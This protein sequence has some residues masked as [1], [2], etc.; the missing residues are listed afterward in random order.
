MGERGCLALQALR[1]AVEDEDDAV[2]NKAAEALSSL[3]TPGL[4]ILVR[5]VRMSP[6]PVKRRAVWGLKLPIGEVGRMDPAVVQNAVRVLIEALA[7]KDVQIRRNAAEAL[8]GYEQHAQPAIPLLIRALSDTH[9]RVRV[10][11]AQTLAFLPPQIGGIIAPAIHLLADASHEVFLEIVSRLAFIGRRASP[12]APAIVRRLAN[13]KRRDRADINHA[14]SMFGPDAVPALAELLKSSNVRKRWLAVEALGEF[15]PYCP[16]AI[17][18]LMAAFQDADIRVRQRATVALRLYGPEAELA[19]PSLVDLLQSPNAKLRGAAARALVQL[20]P[21]ARSARPILIQAAKDD[22]GQVRFHSLQ[23]LARL[24]VE[25][26]SLVDTFIEAL[27]DPDKVVCGVA[28]EALQM[29]GSRAK[30]AVPAL[31]KIRT[32]DWLRPK[33]DVAL[34]RCGHDVAPIVRYWIAELK[35]FKDRWG[36]AAQTLGEIGAPAAEAEPLLREMLRRG[37]RRAWKFSTSMKRAFGLLGVVDTAEALWN[38]SHRPD[39]VMPFLTQL[40]VGEGLGITRRVCDVLSLMGSAAKDAVPALVRALQRDGYW[41]L[42][43]QASEALCAIGPEARTAI[44]TLVEA[45]KKPYSAPW[46]ADVL[47]S[48]G[49]AAVPALIQELRTGDA[50]TREWAAEALGQ[51]GPA[52]AA[53]A[54]HLTGLLHD[55]PPLRWWAAIA[56]TAIQPSSAALR[57]LIEALQAEYHPDVRHGAAEALGRM[58]DLAKS[59]IPLLKQALEDGARNVREAAHLAFQRLQA[60]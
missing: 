57:P 9:P 59:A 40:L 39:D 1:V 41:C 12:A 44:P 51:I 15:F 3:G 52:A 54:P 47:G 29:L 42:Q 58:G 55:L 45:L 16:A 38:I 56:L 36:R 23:A 17:A 43:S 13:F 2:G 50:H 21:A 11:A 18:A 4:R 8:R 33:I 34:V 37:S 19:I 31:L 25:D 32:R 53:A 28:V 48:I 60:L 22:S 27:T 10:G 46:A 49:P 5:L 26:D 6:V 20:G 35:R 24:A 7:H 14:L 30:A